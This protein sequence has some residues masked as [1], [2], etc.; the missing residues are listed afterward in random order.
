[1]A[2]VVG[3]GAPAVLGEVRVELLLGVSAA[4]VAVLRDEGR[5]VRVQPVARPAPVQRGPHEVADEQV[6]EDLVAQRLHER[7]ARDL[8]RDPVA[9][10][11][12][13]QLHHRVLPAHAHRHEVEPAPQ[14]R[15]RLEVRAHRAH[16]VGL[17]RL[18]PVVAELPRRDE[19]RRRLRRVE[20]RHPIVRAVVAEEGRQ[21]PVGRQVEARPVVVDPRAVLVRPHAVL[22]L[23]GVERA[24]RREVRDAEPLHLGGDVAPA[25]VALRGHRQ[26]VGARLVVQVDHVGVAEPGEAQQ[27]RGRVLADDPLHERLPSAVV[28]V[29]LVDD[30][31]APGDPA[32]VVQSPAFV[33]LP[34]GCTR[35]D[36]GVCLAMVIRDD[37]ADASLAVG[38]D[39]VRRDVPDAQATLARSWP[40]HTPLSGEPVALSTVEGLHDM[41]LR[42]FVDGT[43]RQDGRISDFVVAPAV[44]LDSIRRRI[45][46]HDGDIVLTGTPPGLA[47]DRGDGWLLPGNELVAVIDGVGELRTSV[48]AATEARPSSRSSRS[49]P[50][51]FVTGTNYQSHVDEMG[52]SR[53]TVPT[54]NLI[55]SPDAV[56]NSGVDVPLPAETLVDYEGEIAVVIGAHASDVAPRDVDDVVVGFCLANDVTARDAPTTHLSLAKNARRFCPLGPVVSVPPARWGE[57]SF[58]VR[59]N[60][61]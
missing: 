35:L 16:L 12:G 58:T 54:A 50:R 44:L 26:E 23:I 59:V 40:T 39:V 2:E 49:G 56:C 43:C 22:A 18:A 9:E 38:L 20:R 30:E 11:A 25:G 17:E 21:H 57:L 29:V 4:A 36:A 32:S 14:V 19:L 41:R 42:L 46:L 3:A 8:E 52:G 60:G 34:P 55:K 1:M 48:G 24:E 37:G 45:A 5:E 61:A 6:V 31:P 47:F 10:P 53:P 27:D 13:R 51:V 7:A 15:E 33:E 28:G